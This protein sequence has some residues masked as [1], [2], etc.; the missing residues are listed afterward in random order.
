MANKIVE[1]RIVNGVAI[2]DNVPDGV[3]VLIRDYDNLCPP[4]RCEL[5]IDNE[6]NSYIGSYYKG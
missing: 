6:G 1:I 3:H 5:S 2:V 4:P